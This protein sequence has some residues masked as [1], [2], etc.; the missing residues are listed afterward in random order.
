MLARRACA[1]AL[2]GLPVSSSLLGRSRAFTATTATPG[3]ARA[4]TLADITPDG[5]ASFTKKQQEF[6]EGLVAAQKQK[7]Q[8]E[9]A[10]QCTPGTE[11]ANAI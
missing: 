1:H 9:S 4:P 6:R 11:L 7:E 2:N 10:Y 3:P 8:Q 5:A